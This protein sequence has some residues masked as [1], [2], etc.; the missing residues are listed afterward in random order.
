MLA[1]V[2]EV[3]HNWFGTPMKY[4]FLGERELKVI[5]KRGD[6]L[7]GENLWDVLQVTYVLD[8]ET[9]NPDNDYVKI[10]IRQ[11]RNYQFGI[12]IAI[13][14]NRIINTNQYDKNNTHYDNVQC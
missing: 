11:C 12:E 7:E 9:Q 8:V 2:Y 13:T 5:P 10:Y 1:K 4:K 3:I 6:C 14:L